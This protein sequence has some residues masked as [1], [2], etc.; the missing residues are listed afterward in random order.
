M[1]GSV[2]PLVGA[3]T[4]GRLDRHTIEDLG[5]PAAL[6]MESAGRA[7]TEAVLQCWSSG[8]PV[9][10][11]CGAGN[12]GGDGLVVARHLQLLGVPVQLALLGRGPVRGPAAENLARVRALPIPV[13]GERWRVAPGS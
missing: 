11:V 10:V 3:E 1:I 4:M 9:L 5:V 8:Q 2:W 13:L 12:N 6:L 7:V